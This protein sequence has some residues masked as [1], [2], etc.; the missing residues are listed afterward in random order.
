[1]APAPGFP[2]KLARLQACYRCGA[3]ASP[4]APVCAA[5]GLPFESEAP[6]E[7]PAARPHVFLA[8]RFRVVPLALLAAGLFLVALMPLFLSG[9]LFRTPEAV[10]AMRVLGWMAIGVGA[11]LAITGGSLFR[12]W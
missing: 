2:S 4:E 11:W 5:C 10:F 8:Q 12:D 9:P 1:M 3:D 7:S 6:A